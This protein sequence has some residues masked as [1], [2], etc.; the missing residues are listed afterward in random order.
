MTDENK[1]ER[2]HQGGSYVREKDG[3]L[4]QVRKPAKSATA[5]ARPKGSAKKSAAKSK[6]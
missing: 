4:K 2:P 1:I 3:S 6:K 5:Q